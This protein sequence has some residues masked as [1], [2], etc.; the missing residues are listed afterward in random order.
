MSILTTSTPATEIRKAVVETIGAVDKDGQKN[1]GDYWENLAQVPCI[2]Y[3][4]TFRKKSVPMLA[5]SDLSN[6][7]NAIHLTFV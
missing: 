2:W 6:E 1:E 3:F 7:I 5:L 4:I